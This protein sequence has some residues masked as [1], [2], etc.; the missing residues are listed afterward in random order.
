MNNTRTGGYLLYT[1]DGRMNNTRVDG[2]AAILVGRT[3][4][5]GKYVI[6]TYQA[7]KQ[8]GAC[9]VVVK[10]TAGG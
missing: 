1:V 2:R 4:H 9:Y 10:G 6:K 3:P 7:R 8:S 5:E